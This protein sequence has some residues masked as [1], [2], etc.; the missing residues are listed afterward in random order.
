MLDE[1]EALARFGP[2]DH[3]AHADAAEESLLAIVGS[4]DFHA[5]GCRLQHLHSFRFTLPSIEFCYPT[6]I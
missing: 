2:V 5:R 4:Y 1:R 6:I 3:E